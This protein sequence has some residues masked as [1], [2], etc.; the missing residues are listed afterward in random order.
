MYT[1]GFYDELVQIENGIREY[2]LDK[3]YLYQD[4]AAKI[5]TVMSYLAYG[6][7]DEFELEEI[8]GVHEKSV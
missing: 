8:G 4:R 3:L 2:D 7:N 1:K 6:S 5:R